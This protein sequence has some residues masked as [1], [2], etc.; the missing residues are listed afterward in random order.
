[1]HRETDTQ[2]QQGK[3]Y[4]NPDHMGFRIQAGALRERAGAGQHCL[5]HREPLTNSGAELAE[6]GRSVMSVR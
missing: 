2:H 3:E 6:G 4:D 5:G 1:M